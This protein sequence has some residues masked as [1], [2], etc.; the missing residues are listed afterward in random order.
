MFLYINESQVKWIRTITYIKGIDS[1]LDRKARS[2]EFAVL[3]HRIHDT[4]HGSVGGL[5]VIL[6]DG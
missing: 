1:V 2:V 4:G 5:V 3:A 6:S